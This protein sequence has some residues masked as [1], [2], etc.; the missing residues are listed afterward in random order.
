MIV[1]DNGE[2]IVEI[3][4]V[5]GLNCIGEVVDLFECDVVEVLV[6]MVVEKFG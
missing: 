2:V 6:D 1:G 5:F 3:C 4:V